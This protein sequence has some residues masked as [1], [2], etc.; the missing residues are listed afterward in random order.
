[1]AQPAAAAPHAYLPR[2][3]SPDYATVHYD[4]D[5]RY[6]VAT[7][8]LDAT[9]TIRGRAVT[10][11]RAVHLD[12]VHLRA[13]RVRLDGD[14]KVRYAQSTTHLTVR[15]SAPI[16]AGQEFTLV[17]DYDGSPSPRRSRWGTI[18]R[19]LLAGWEFEQEGEA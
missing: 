15:P 12:L 9:A 2:S 8:R 16:P 18:R 10:T 19:C 11:L 17:V 7:N 6:R 14:R 5:L 3:G 1:M 4:L 13:K